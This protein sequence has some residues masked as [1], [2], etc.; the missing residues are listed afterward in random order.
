MYEFRI[1]INQADGHPLTE[2][3]IVTIVDSPHAAWQEAIRQ[4]DR[5]A[6]LEHVSSICISPF[7]LTKQ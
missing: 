7:T 4:L 1:A 6:L 2:M 3:K 5:L